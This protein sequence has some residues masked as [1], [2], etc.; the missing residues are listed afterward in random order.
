MR[1]DNLDEVEQLRSRIA[2]LEQL[3]KQSLLVSPLTNA[4]L[5]T[6]RIRVYDAG[7]VVAVLG[8][9]PE[10]GRGVAVRFRGG[11]PSIDTAMQT[12]TAE[13]TAVNNRMNSGGDIRQALVDAR[14]VADGAQSFANAVNA[15]LN[16]GGDIREALSNAQSTAS[17][18]QSAANSAQST[19]NAANSA[20]GTAWNYADSAYARASTALSMAQDA[21]TVANHVAARYNAHNHGGSPS[22]GPTTPA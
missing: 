3:V 8:T 5:T 15:R 4:S 10:G 13:T 21:L 7:S 9:L 2:A 20:A 18:A 16:S 12:L 1:H 17:S 14:A 22:N 6:G 19:A 11:L